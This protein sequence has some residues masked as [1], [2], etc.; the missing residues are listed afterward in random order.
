[1]KQH[2][3]REDY[4]TILIAM[5]LEGVRVPKATAMGFRT[6]SESVIWDDVL[7]SSRGPAS[8]DSHDKLTQFGFL[9]RY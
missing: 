4:L 7:G 9:P 2:Q 6:R 8:A 3:R 5:L 1:M